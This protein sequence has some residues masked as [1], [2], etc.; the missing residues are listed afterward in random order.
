MASLKWDLNDFE[1]YID[2]EADKCILMEPQHMPSAEEQGKARISRVRQKRFV[3][4]VRL[5]C[6]EVKIE[7]AIVNT[8]RLRAYFATV[9]LNAGAEDAEMR[10]AGQD[11]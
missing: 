3:R 5:L 6:P 4:I 9:A 1:E 11:S 7:A 10:N 8:S 2:L